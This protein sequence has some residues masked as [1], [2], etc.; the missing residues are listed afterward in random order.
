MF[1][2]KRH[3]KQTMLLIKKQLQKVNNL[4]QGYSLAHNSE[5]IAVR[6]SL[7]IM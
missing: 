5:I 6:S 1:K 4:N 2:E 7:K 3:V